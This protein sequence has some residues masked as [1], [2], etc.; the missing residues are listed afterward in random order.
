MTAAGCEAARQPTLAWRGLRILLLLW[1]GM[2]LGISF[3]AIPLLFGTPTLDRPVAFDVVRHI[4]R[5]FVWLQ[6]GIFAALLLGAA[7]ARPGRMIWWLLALVGL[8]SLVQALWLVP[9][10]DAR[11]SLILAGQE[12]PAGPWHRIN[13]ILEVMKVLALLLAAWRVEST[14]SAQASGAIAKN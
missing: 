10:L 8:A 6:L 4:F 9:I 13:E 14:W 3:F 2:L 12:P 5:P 11:T 7:I 1:A